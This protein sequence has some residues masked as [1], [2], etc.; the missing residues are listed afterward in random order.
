MLC[1]IGHQLALSLSSVQC[2]VAWLSEESRQSLGLLSVCRNSTWSSCR[3]SIRAME[4][5]FHSMIRTLALSTC[6][7][8]LVCVYVCICIALCQSVSW[9]LIFIYCLISSYCLTVFI[10]IYL[11][12]T[13]SYHDSE[14]KVMD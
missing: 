9:S 4:S 14:R 8:R 10:C 5:S 2:C 11:C 13:R 12:D 6:A 7:A 1:R 3:K